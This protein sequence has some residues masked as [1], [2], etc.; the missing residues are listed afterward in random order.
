MTA[1]DHDTKKDVRQMPL[2]KV[3]LHNDD[4]NS[5]DHVIKALLEV[6]KFELQACIKIMMDA[7]ETGVALAKIEPLE[8]AELHQNQLQAFG[9]TATIEPE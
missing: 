9:L 6:F 4:V 2:Y 8:T 1:T 7:H 5:M 3:L